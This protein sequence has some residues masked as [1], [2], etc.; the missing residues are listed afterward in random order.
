MNNKITMFDYNADWAL[1]T[2][3]LDPRPV[4]GYLTREEVIQFFG[5]LG[6]DG[7]EIREDYW[8]DCSVQYLKQLTQDA[9]LPIVSYVF[10]VDLAQPT[11]EKRRTAVDEA[12]RLMDRT[13]ELGAKIA[14]IFPGE[15]KDGYEIS[16]L[17]A[18]VI[19]GLGECAAHA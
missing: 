9:G 18:W 14:M 8:S 3:N 11:A 1:K 4:P 6:V 15:N 7:V 2:G 10:T 12:R 5:T 16:Q 13:A 19:E 17:T